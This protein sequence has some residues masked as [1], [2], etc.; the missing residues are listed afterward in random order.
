MRCPL[1]CLSDNAVIIDKQQSRS[2]RGVVYACL[3]VKVVRR[4]CVNVH[5]VV[6]YTGSLDCRPDPTEST[7]TI[8]YCDTDK[9]NGAVMT[10]SLG[11]VM[12][13]VALFINVIVGHLL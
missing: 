11:H 6:Q 3:D 12:I 5:E 9:C 4:G 8:C 7:G 10:S 13:V 1:Q 2:I